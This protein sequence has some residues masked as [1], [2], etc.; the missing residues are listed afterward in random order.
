MLR[1]TSLRLDTQLAPTILVGP[2]NSGKTSMAEALQLFTSG[3]A[4]G[5]STSDFSLSCRKE[6]DLVEEAFLARLP[7]AQAGEAAAP[8]PGAVA[9]LPLMSMTLQFEYEDIA[10][11]LAVV[12]D[13]LMDLDETS[14]VVSVQIEFAP[15]DEAKLKTNF[16]SERGD[17]ESLFT[18]LGAR[19]QDHY[20]ISYYKRLAATGER[21]LLQDGAVLKRLVHVDF[22]NAQRH[23]D[24]QEGGQATRLS[25]LLH[26]YYERHYRD[27]EPQGYRDLEEQLAANSEDLSGRY[28]KAFAGLIDG[29]EQFGYPQDRAPQLSIKAELNAE[30]LFKD[31]T[32]LYY[33][34]EMETDAPHL[35]AQPYELPE[36]YN[37][38][39]FKNL[40]FMI[41]QLQ[42]FREDIAKSESAPPR[43]H[44]VIIEE[45]EVHLHP[46][47]QSVFIK[48]IASFLA[49]DSD[50]VGVQ[51]ILTTHSSHIVAD[52]GFTPVRY[53]RRERG[54]VDVKD[55]LEFQSVARDAN[56]VA[57]IQFLTRYLTQ[58]RCDLF[59]A[60]KAILLE[61]QVERLLLPNMIAKCAIGAHAKLAADY[62]VV[63]EVG[64][65]Y[66]HVFKELLAF[67][68][69]PTLIV[70]DLD[71][72]DG[73]RK[74]C[75]VANAISTSNAVLQ[76]WLPGK[77][78][79]AELLEAS[80]DQKTDKSVRVAYQV[81]ETPE[82][83]C[84][85]S[86][87]ESFIYSNAE[88]LIANRDQLIATKG[89]FAFPTAL[90]LREE[91]FAVRVH[92]VDFALDLIQV[93]GWQTPKYIADGLEWLA[94]QDA[95]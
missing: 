12:A 44:V 51:L 16:R 89:V 29:L 2:N 50:R 65:A 6:F 40:I 14:R 83:P 11:D 10:A 30:T 57:A 80:N 78:S 77:S 37:G 27:T 93:E 49:A 71:S 68:A 73:E 59:F 20:G 60:D 39:G 86:F 3:S 58:M 43:A 92:K 23:I 61:G 94:Q 18:F 67:I 56:G 4:K 79:I 8:T 91:A 32:R 5:F 42:S 33:T 87:E 48:Q 54:K 34:A 45:P 36:K 63:I 82:S 46:Q 53:F 1:A 21:E 41:L 95:P 70:A 7:E 15:L 35:S 85:R 24:D 31:S 22:I 69:L 90:K 84:A 52:C 47:V 74:K 76:K 81:P 72:V 19:L 88:W 64:G 28:A 26:R 38:L 17:H 9:N 25:S 62:I 13:L 55:L 66:A 75:R